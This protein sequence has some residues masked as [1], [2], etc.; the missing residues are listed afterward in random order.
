LY[1]D[2]TATSIMTRSIARSYYRDA[3]GALIVFDVTRR[4]TFQNLYLWLA[5]ARAYGKPSISIM[6]VA[7]KVD[8]TQK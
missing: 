8:I 6:I 1:C 3:A 4:E 5:D 7:N 2:T